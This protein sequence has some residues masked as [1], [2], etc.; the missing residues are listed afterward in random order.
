MTFKHKLSKR[1]AM[2]R[3]SAV[4]VS[5]ALLVG[6]A[7]G[8]RALA[9]DAPSFLSTISQPATVTDLTVAGVTANSVTL[10]FTERDDGTG[11]PAKY[12]FRYAV[13]TIDF[14]SAVDVA[15][16]T[17]LRPVIGT[18]IGATRTCT[19]LGLT[20]GTGYEVQLI[21]Y[22]GTLDSNAVF[23]DLSNVVSATTRSSAP[24]TVTDLTVAGVTASS[25]TLAF[26]E[27][28]DG[29]GQPAKYDFRYAVGIIAFGSAVDVAQGT[30]VRPV[31]GTG[32]GAKRTC[33]ILGLA[34]ASS[35][36]MQLITYRGTLD[37]NAVF[38]HLSNVASATTAG[39]TALVASVTVTPATASV[40][41]G[42]TQ[43]VTAT[44]RD[45]GGSVLSGRPVTWS[46]S[47]PAVAT[48]SGSGV[49]TAVAAGT[50][51]ITATSEGQSGTAAVTVA[52]AA[53]PS[54][55]GSVNDLALAGA[56]TNSLTLSFTEVDDGTG[57]P[58]KYDFRYAVGTIAFGSA[59]DVAQGTC[60]RPV[61]G[62]GIG[63]KRTCTILGLAPAS[64][65]QMQLITYRG[66]L[67]SNAVFGDL[68]NVVSAT[69]AGTIAPAA[70]VA[71]VTVG[72]A[73]ASVVIGGTQAFTATLRDASGS[74]LTGRVVTWAS[75]ALTVATVSGSGV[76]TGLLVGTATITASS[77]GQSGS[78][79]LTVTLPGSGGVLFQSDWSTATGTSAA[80]VTDGGRW[81][82]WWEFDDDHSGTQLL[83]VVAGGPGGRNAL[84]VMQR[85]EDAAFLQ[86]YNVLPLSTD[87]YF[88]FYMRNDDTSPNGD[89]IVTVDMYQYPNLTF[90]RKFSS[91]TDWRFVMSLYGCGYTYPIGHWNPGLS[92]QHG[93]WYR[94]EYFVDF[95]DATHVQVHPRVY[96]AA[97]TLI[98]SDADFRQEDPGSAVWNGRSDWTLASYYAAGNSFCVV[99]GPMTGAAVGN[100]GQAGAANTGLFWYYA[101]IQLRTDRWPGP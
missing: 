30:C 66:T 35:Y 98:A 38:G 57:R 52:A 14:G 73:S 6:C 24:R 75:N 17:C 58:A 92:L 22:R 62:T 64:S 18:G 100:N 37:S 59:I 33:T 65:Y 50:T 12:D 34:P 9:P 26:T 80:A 95:V 55:P 32:I 67:D 60:V 93:V 84:R 49:A 81:G 63:A 2:M 41:V 97:G 53:P 85:S 40:S 91:P 48:V 54:A 27:V 36:Q 88:R 82:N 19:I 71:S 44:P 46:S 43:Q 94:F 74:V 99:P 72:P 39:A 29:T 3:D 15:Q 51:T 76:A 68:S 47:A 56:A 23:G 87:F 31:I 1:L 21:T 89:H 13:G 83:S 90:M 42:A 77:E 25:V 70:P 5:A 78:A 8:D 61:I 69:T 4:V 79:T 20:P 45:S 101:G 28:G 86:Q 11:L 96:D 16:G 10:A 7:P